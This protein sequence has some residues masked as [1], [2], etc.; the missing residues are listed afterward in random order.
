MSMLRRKLPSP[1]IVIAILALVAGVTGA[2]VAQPVAKKAVTKKK[3]K[4]IAKKEIKKAAPDLSVANAES[5]GDHPADDYTRAKFA[6]I[7][8]NGT[9][10]ADSKGIAQVNVTKDGAGF[11][12]IDGLSDPEPK[13]VSATLRTDALAGARLYAGLKEGGGVC[14]GKQIIV[15]TQNNALTNTDNPFTIVVF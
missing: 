2:A 7:N 14:A 5:L 3:V 6:S 11:Y 13:G 10:T 12:C 8:A 15:Q 4:K 1:A 9:V